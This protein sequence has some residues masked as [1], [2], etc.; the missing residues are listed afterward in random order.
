MEDLYQKVMQLAGMLP[1]RTG[2]NMDCDLF[3]QRLYSLFRSYSLETQIYRGDNTH[4]WANDP[5][6]LSFVTAVKNDDW[7]EIYDLTVDQPLIAYV[8]SFRDVVNYMQ[9]SYGGIWRQTTK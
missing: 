5:Q 6:P 9:N 4:Q 2:E 7:I 8:N 1:G 3:S